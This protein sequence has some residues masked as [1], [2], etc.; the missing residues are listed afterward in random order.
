[1]TYS[2][3]LTILLFALIILFILSYG[4]SNENDNINSKK[5][6]YGWSQN[7][8]NYKMTN[9]IQQVLDDYNIK[10]VD[11]HLSDIIFPCTYDEINKE[12]DEFK[13][14]ENPNA[15]FFIIKDADQ[16][17]GKDLLWFNLVNYYG[18]LKASSIMPMSYILINPDDINRFKKDFNKN[19]LYILKK[20]IQR[21]EGLKITNNLDEILDAK[22]DNYVIVQKLLQ[23][24]YIIS[25]NINNTINNRKINMRFYILV[26][27]KYNNIY[28]YVH[29]NG[30]MYYTPES[31]I[32]GSLDMNSNIT[33][34][35]I[36]RQVYDVNPLTHHDF[37]KYLDN[38]ERQ[39]NIYETHIRNQ[40]LI[41]SN[42]VFK[43][44]YDLLRDVFIA[45]YN[46]INK[47]SKIFDKISFQLF[48]A[49]IAINNQLIPS[50]MEINKGPDL[51]SKDKRDG[52]VKY[53][54]V[55]DIFRTIH[56]INDNN[57]NNFI[58]ILSINNG[59]II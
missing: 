7:V 35:Y 9:T 15:K 8:C 29:D 43:R 33:S 16:I 44:I 46:K 19:N 27:C 54:V 42:V 5:T 59:I 12:I 17:I 56:I 1:M 53:K 37:I 14:N 45:V 48:G 20:N 6:N 25:D 30:F 39:L 32:K 47:N 34:G 24:P 28:V 58:H 10:R 13:P 57:T 23:D 2:Y 52:D 21:Q 49:D 22:K 26:V 11:N 55:S 50:L 41:I 51:G 38:S 40:Q 36:D 4:P 18:I 31:F 3:I